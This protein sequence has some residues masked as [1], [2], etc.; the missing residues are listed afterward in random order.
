MYCFPCPVFN[1]IGIIRLSRNNYICVLLDIN[2]HFCRS[3]IHRVPLRIALNHLNVVP[4]SRLMIDKGFDFG[5]A[6]PFR[7]IIEARK[8]LTQGARNYHSHTHTSSMWKRTRDREKPKEDSTKTNTQLGGRPN[9][10]RIIGKM[11]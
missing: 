5:L 7:A 8:T 2:G 4:M 9:D 10:Y 3:T 11:V 1:N 6:S